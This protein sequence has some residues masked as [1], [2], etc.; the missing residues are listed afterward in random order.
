M[1]YAHY[2][3]HPT[4]FVGVNLDS[5]S[6][7]YLGGSSEVFQ[8]SAGEK[9]LSL[10]PHAWYVCKYEVVSTCRCSFLPLMRSHRQSY[11]Y[12]CRGRH[13]VLDISTRGFRTH[14]IHLAYSSSSNSPILKRFLPLTRTCK[15]DCSAVTLPGSRPGSQVDSWALAIFG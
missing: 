11:A 2:F 1:Q 9:G 8:K 5:K 10:S 7:E 4:G 13:R 12:T 3:L 14:A 6:W 15:V